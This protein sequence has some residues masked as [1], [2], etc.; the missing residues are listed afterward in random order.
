MPVPIFS[1]AAISFFL[2]LTARARKN[3]FNQALLPGFAGEGGRR[4]ARESQ[5]R[6]MRDGQEKG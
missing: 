5:R 6:R 3:D 1:C 2:T 4:A